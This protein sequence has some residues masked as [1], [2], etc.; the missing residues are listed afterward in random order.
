MFLKQGDVVTAYLNADMDEQ[1]YIKLPKICGD[2]E[3]FVGE[4]WKAL[5]GRPKAGQLWNNT[6]VNTMTK[7]GFKQSSQKRCFLYTMANPFILCSMLM[8]CWLLATIRRFWRNFGANY[9][10]PTRFET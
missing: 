2:E 4:L 8:M 7:M 9:A 3:G 1:V 10:Q 6:F 5:Y